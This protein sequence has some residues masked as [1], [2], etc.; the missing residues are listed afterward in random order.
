MPQGIPTG[1]S[2]S[3]RIYAF[4]V[5]AR[6]G[7]GKRH[8]PRRR[9]KALLRVPVGGNAAR[10]SHRT[11]MLQADL[12]ICRACTSVH[13]R[14]KRIYAFAVLAR[15][16]IGKRHVPRRRRKALLRVPVGGNAARHSHRTL[17]LLHQP[18]SDYYGAWRR[19]TKR[20]ARS[21]PTTIRTSSSGSSRWWKRGRNTTT[22]PRKRKHGEKPTEKG[23]RVRSLFCFAAYG[24]RE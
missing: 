24:G 13:T 16:G 3:K 2:C 15:A 1:H 12:R 11:L 20:R 18:F 21:S 4:A 22:L 6:A 23:E 19:W 9:R 7:I 14:C 5:L 10:H 8:V 17:M